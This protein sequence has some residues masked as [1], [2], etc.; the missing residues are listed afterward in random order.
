MRRPLCNYQALSISVLL[1][2]WKQASLDSGWRFQ[3]DWATSETSRFAQ[4]FVL[5]DEKMGQAARRL[6]YS[7]ATQG[8]G[9]TET[10]DDLLAFFGAVSLPSDPL[11]QQR[12]SEGWV[13]AA[14]VAHPSSCIEPLT[15]LPTYEHFGRVLVEL[16]KTPAFEPECFVIGTIRIP[17]QLEGAKFGWAA[18]V[19]LGT[20]CRDTLETAS[21]SL[22]YQDGAIRILMQRTNENYGR[23]ISCHAAIASMDHFRWDQVTITYENLPSSRS[24][25]LAEFPDTN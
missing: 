6:G 10:I 14:E 25:F 7:R 1:L 22:A 3:D 2:K 13:A 9:I 12:L 5:Q 18:L 23:M 16:Y 24:P 8:I 4:A 19:E 20:H 21:A 11:L 17:A 15:G